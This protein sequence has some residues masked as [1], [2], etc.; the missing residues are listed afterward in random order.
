M[1]RS[2]GSATAAPTTHSRAENLLLGKPLTA[3][4][5]AWI[6]ASVTVSITIIAGVLIHFTDEQ[7][8]PNIGDG[9]WWAVQTVTTVGYGDLVPTS[10]TGRL[11]AALVMIGGIGFLTVVTAAITSTFIENARRRIRGTESDVVS[12]KLDRISER[13]DVIDTALKDI[14]APERDQ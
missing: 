11:L 10:I 7:N 14:A 3:P 12:A 4:R 6:I 9:L 13:L 2:K 1:T 8:F 5:A